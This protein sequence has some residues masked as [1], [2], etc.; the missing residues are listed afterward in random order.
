MDKL[1]QAKEQGKIAYFTLDRLIIKDR[2][3]DD[4]TSA[5]HPRPKTRAFSQSMHDKYVTQ[6]CY[7]LSIHPQSLIERTESFDDSLD[8][9]TRNT[10]K[11]ITGRIPNGRG[12]EQ[13]G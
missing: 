2:K 13:S 5:D 11:W 7:V 4:V 10:S 6:L 12:P 1:Q 9:V 8:F 3:A